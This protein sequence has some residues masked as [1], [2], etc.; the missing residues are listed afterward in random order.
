[1]SVTTR[2]PRPTGIPVRRPAVDLAHAD[3]DRWLVRGDPVLSHVLAGLSA[4]FPNGEDFFVDSVRNYRDRFASDQDMKARVKGFIGQESM[5]GREHRAFNKRL[6]GRGYP[7]DAL[8]AGLL[9]AATRARRLPKAL[10]LSITAASEHLTSTFAHAVLGHEPTRQILFPDPEVELLITWHAL[11]ELE[12]K[13]VAFDVLHDVSPGY[14]LRVSGLLLAAVYWGP[15]VVFGVARGLVRDRRHITPRALGRA[16][17]HFTRQR[18]LGPW[19]WVGIAKYLRPGFH[20]RDID[21][22]ALVF[23]WRER[24]APQMSSTKA[25]SAS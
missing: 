12:H 24:L 13:D 17:R 15:V 11:E 23:E 6:A 10:Q 14:L 5:H 21:T 18:M 4:V 7:T 22:D 25:V 3:V 16:A 8:D 9:R 19:A 20:P 2:V 1:M